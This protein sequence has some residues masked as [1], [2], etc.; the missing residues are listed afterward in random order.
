[1]SKDKKGLPA[2]ALRTKEEQ[3]EWMTKWYIE[4][5]EKDM[6]KLIDG[7]IERAEF[8]VQELKSRK[9]LMNEIKNAEEA[10]NIRCT[11]KLEDAFKWAFNAISNYNQNVRV[12][13]AM[14]IIGEYKAA[15]AI[16]NHIDGRDI[17]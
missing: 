10:M 7:E 15:K 9:A 13:S 14:D 4:K 16:K 5:G 12:Q 2:V 1:M 6:E 8:L 17:F 11:T 3:Q